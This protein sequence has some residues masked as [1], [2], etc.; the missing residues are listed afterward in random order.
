MIELPK[1]KVGAPEQAAQLETIPPGPY[2]LIWQHD[3]QDFRANKQ[4]RMIKVDE[5]ELR[6]GYSTWVVTDEGP[7]M[8]G[9]H[10]DTSD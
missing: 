10:R 6:W 1:N 8:V 5:F 3:E 4:V 2:Y 9:Y 7:V